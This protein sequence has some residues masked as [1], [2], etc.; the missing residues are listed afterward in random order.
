MWVLTPS[1]AWG[2]GAA[3]K[4]ITRLI[5]TFLLALLSPRSS[6]LSL[7]TNKSRTKK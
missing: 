7:A 2:V 5:R 6:F 3:Q 1:V 4:A